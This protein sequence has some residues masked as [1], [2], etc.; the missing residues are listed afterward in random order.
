M[1][2]RLGLPE[3]KTTSLHQSIKFSRINID[4]TTMKGA[5]PDM[6]KNSAVG[7][8]RA[9]LTKARHLG[10]VQRSRSVGMIEFGQPA[11]STRKGKGHRAACHESRRAELASAQSEEKMNMGRRKWGSSVYLK[12]PTIK[13]GARTKSGKE[14]DG[15]TM[16][17]GKNRKGEDCLS[18]LP[19]THWDKPMNGERSVAKMRILNIH[20]RKKLRLGAVHLQEVLSRVRPEP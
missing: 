8:P 2:L 13:E 18:Y 14:C 5:L 12:K 7:S 6:R 4:A 15:L 9:L 17:R 16:R 20:T 3:S 11:G 19:K 10:G 1:D